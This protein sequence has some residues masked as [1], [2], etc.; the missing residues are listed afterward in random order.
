[1]RNIELLKQIKNKDIFIDNIIEFLSNCLDWVPISIFQKGKAELEI[2]EENLEEFLHI[3]ST[4]KFNV[5]SYTFFVRYFT[6]NEVEENK[7]RINIEVEY[8]TLKK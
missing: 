1:M 5:G 7:M 3:I 8:Q 6:F 4:N 2:R